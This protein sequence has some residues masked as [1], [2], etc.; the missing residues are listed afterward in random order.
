[1]STNTATNLYTFS[2]QE[3]HVFSPTLLNIATLGFSRAFS[4]QVTAPLTPLPA[5]LL[6]VTGG[7]GNNPGLIGIT[8]SN[9]ISPQGALGIG[10]IN[11][12]NAARQNYT[13]ADDL[14][15]T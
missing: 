5:S 11:S 10:G 3:T 8:G 12:V 1:F 7:A 15:V 2:T 13:V 9:F 6:M 14:K 4:T